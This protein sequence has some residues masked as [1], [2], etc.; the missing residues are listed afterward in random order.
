MSFDKFKDIAEFVALVAIV[1]SLIAVTM[2]LRQ[3]QAALQAQTY[4]ARAFD[5]IALNLEIALN[6]ELRLLPADFDIETLTADE[7]IVT[8]RLYNAFLVDLDNEH[9]QYQNGFLDSDY[10]FGSTVREIK[11]SAPIWRKLGI[12]ERREEF[13]LEVDRILE[14]PSIPELPGLVPQSSR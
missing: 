12:V 10:Y 9:Y 13:R 6:P 11:T 4:Q 14:D 3:T 8:T 1:G 2:E 7:F 5:A